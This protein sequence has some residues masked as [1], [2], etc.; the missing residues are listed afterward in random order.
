MILPDLTIVT[1]EILEIHV[2]LFSILREKIPPEMKGRIVLHLNDGA[3]AADL[4]KELDINRRV[5]VS[6]NDVQ[7]RDHSQ[8]LRNGD[9]VKVFTSVGGG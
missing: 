8:T 7:I 9:R 3:T 6:L 4:L 1:G 2:Q 5:A